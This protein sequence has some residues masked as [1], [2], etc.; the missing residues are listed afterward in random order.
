MKLQITLRGPL[1]AILETQ[2]FASGFRKRQFVVENKDEKEAKWDQPICFEFHKDNCDKL[3]Y[4]E[5]GDEVEVT[6]DVQG[7]EHNGKHYVSLRAWKLVKL[8][9]DGEPSRDRASRPPERERPEVEHERNRARHT[10]R[11][12]AKGEEDEIPF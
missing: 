6:A 4:F 3:D 8:G 9:A 11:A 1:V 7:N 10:A 12:G 2:S 5:V